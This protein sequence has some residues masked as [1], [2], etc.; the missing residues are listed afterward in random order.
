MAREAGAP[1]GLSV[2]IIERFLRTADETWDGAATAAIHVGLSE[3]ANR[4]ETAVAAMGDAI[5]AAALGGEA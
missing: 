4:G 2:S 3:P 1:D 5:R